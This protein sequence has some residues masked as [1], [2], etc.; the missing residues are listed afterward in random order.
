MSVVARKSDRSRGSSVYPPA[1]RGGS[2]C[3]VIRE[4]TRIAR[5]IEAAAL[6][7]IA[8]IAGRQ[9]RPVDAASPLIQWAGM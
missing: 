1:G 3:T 8:V 9:H 2:V 5:R 6:L 4:P 7:A